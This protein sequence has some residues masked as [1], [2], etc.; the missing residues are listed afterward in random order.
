MKGPWRRR[1]SKDEDYKG[2]RTRG[3]HITL[4]D[5]EMELLK[6]L[7]EPGETF[8]SG[9]RKQIY[10]ATPMEEWYEQPT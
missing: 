9:V 2:P 7:L 3:V 6:R 10:L 4:S 5:H 1:N 8:S